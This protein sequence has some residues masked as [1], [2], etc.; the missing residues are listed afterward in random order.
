MEP[1][2]AANEVEKTRDTDDSGVTTITTVV[3]TD[4]DGDGIPDYLDVN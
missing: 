1:V 3:F 4:T 2:L